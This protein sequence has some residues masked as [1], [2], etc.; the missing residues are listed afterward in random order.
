MA[1]IDKIFSTLKNA[2]GGIELIIEVSDKEKAYNTLRR[3]GRCRAFELIPYLALECSVKDAER[4]ASLKYKERRSWLLSREV[5]S[6]LEQILS[7][8]PSAKVSIPPMRKGINY[9][10]DHGERLWNL[11]NIGAYEAWKLST[12]SEVSVGVID[13]GCDYSHPEIS[14]RFSDDKGFDFILNNSKPMDLNGHGTH[15]A[16]IIAGRNCG[17]APGARLYALRVLDEDGSGSEATVMLGIEW[18]L[19]K[20]LQIVNMSLGAPDYSE[21]FKELCYYAH[22]HGLIMCAAAGNDAAPIYDYPASFQPVISVAAVDRMNR[23]AYFSNINDL[24]DISAPGVEIVSSYPGGSYRM[25]SGTSMAAPH[26][27][28]AIALGLSLGM[29][30]N[31]VERRL[32]DTAQPISQQGVPQEA[33]GA[34]L[35]RADAL[36][37]N[38]YDSKI[39]RILS[40]Q[41]SKASVPCWR[42][43]NV[44]RR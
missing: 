25:L 40:G 22:K 6:A 4:L 37:S 29:D 9:S 8:E 16:G 39:A 5:R 7:I 23:H 21:A 24:V 18:A 15:V 2:K 26:V 19:K 11:E 27:S 35:V 43:W 42:D 17:V 20:R 32:A 33:F 28:G 31:L 14:S 30:V 34:G 3:F 41:S 12:G 38:Y 36:L 10:L 44:P 13:T 1:E